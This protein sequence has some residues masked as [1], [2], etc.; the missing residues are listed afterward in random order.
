MAVFGKDAG[1]NLEKIASELI[2]RVNENIRRLRVLENRV[3]ALDNRI[4]SMEQNS[5]VQNKNLQKSLTDR[6]SKIGLLEERLRKTEMTIKEIVKQ[7]R[8]VATKT[9]V[10]ELKHLVDIYNPLKSKFATKEE[11]ENMINEKLA[12]R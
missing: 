7:L 9:N 10:E 8:F 1:A 11:I 5:L 4:N 3:K 2:N 6:D 12:E